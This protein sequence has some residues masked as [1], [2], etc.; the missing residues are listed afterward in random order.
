MVHG[1]IYSKN[2]SD[3]HAGPGEIFSLRWH[4]AVSPGMDHLPSDPAPDPNVLAFIGAE[5]IHPGG[6]WM[7]PTMG[8]GGDLYLIFKARS[9]GS[10]ILTIG[11]C[12]T[13]PDYY[14]S[15]RERSIYH[16]RVG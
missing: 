11:N 4:L 6:L 16:V 9:P 2:V 12:F 7:A 14:A 15:Y 3:I 13:C 1:H 8:D 10:T 5:R